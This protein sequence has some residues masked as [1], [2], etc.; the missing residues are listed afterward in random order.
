[1]LSYA[2]HRH[3]PDTRIGDEDSGGGIQVVECQAFLGGG[4]PERRAFAQHDAAHHTG[5]AATL[6]EWG[7][8][9]A[10]AHEEYIAHCPR[11]QVS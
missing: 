5:D 3:N 9:S 11:D 10:S 4:E 7:G 6:N 8:H 2:S 1:M